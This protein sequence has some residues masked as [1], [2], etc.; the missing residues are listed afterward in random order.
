MAELLDVSLDLRLEVISGVS[1]LLESVDTVA[2]LLDL[3]LQGSWDSTA[4]SWG[5]AT[6]S[7]KVHLSG[8]LLGRHTLKI[9]YSGSRLTYIG[10]PCLV[11]LSP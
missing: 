2:D 6:I 9:G 7:S 11:P 1:L 10:P 4:S 5:S 3:V 8:Q